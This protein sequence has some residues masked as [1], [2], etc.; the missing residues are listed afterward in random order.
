LLVTVDRVLTLCPS[1]ELGHPLAKLHLGF[2]TEQG[3][4]PAEICI[5]R[6]DITYTKFAVVL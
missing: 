6:P 5:T 4:C 3:T 2:I 1:D